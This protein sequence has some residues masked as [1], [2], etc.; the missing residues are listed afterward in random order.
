MKSISTFALAAVLAAGLATTA[1]SAPAAAQKKGKEESGAPQLK[2]SD[3][4]RKPVAAA[5]TALAANDTATA[6][7]QLAAAEAAAK[8]DDETY[9]VNALK[10]QMTAKSNDPAQLSPILDKLLVNPKTPQASL[11]QYNYFRA[12]APWNA[13]RYAEALPYLQK[14]RDLGYVNE[15]LTLQIAAAMTE[16]GNVA[17]GVAEVS[18]AI[19]AETAAGRKAPEAWYSYA[20]GKL[21]DAK[22][23]DL[24]PWLQKQINAYPTA[25]NWRTAL[26][27]YRDSQEKGGTKLD[28]AQQLDLFRLMRAAKSLGARGDYLEYA[29]IAYDTGLP[30][31]TKSVIEE[32]RA[33]GKIPA[34]DA[35]GNRLYSDANNAIK[36]EGSLAGVEAK[37]KAAANGKTAAQTGDAYLALGQAAK[38]VELY[39]VAQQKG[40]V[41]A[42]ELNL[43]LGIAHYNAG[44]KAAAKTAFQAVTAGPRKDMA[45]F[46]V[47]LIDLGV[48][49]G[50][51]A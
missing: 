4:V 20:V 10:L 41:D 46:W 48:T 25:K 34:T 47:Q 3:A 23:P 31:E 11:G 17:G 18:K 35:N 39:T 37:A 15:N 26:L 13:K 40:G 45:A 8:T 42:S 6:T 9:I 19:D 30:G 5:Q 32:G 7:T 36:L 33:T 14:A 21:Y 2:L 51:T 27:V 44:N 1:T 38:A 28:R 22:S 16:T 12:Q 24:S 29:L 43:H 50:T 49:P